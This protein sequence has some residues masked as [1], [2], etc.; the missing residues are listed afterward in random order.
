[1]RILAGYFYLLCYLFVWFWLSFCDC[2]YILTL[3]M[4]TCNYVFYY[5]IF[6]TFLPVNKLSSTSEE[7]RRPKRHIK[8]GAVRSLFHVWHSSDKIAIFSH[9]SSGTKLV[10]NKMASQIICWFDYSFYIH[11][12]VFLLSSTLTTYVQDYCAV[13]IYIYIYIYI[14]VL[15]EIIQAPSVIT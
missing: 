3:G 1:M 2:I 15:H 5:I 13:Y 7:G 11:A 14:Y 4:N 6:L 10:S 12:P 8:A 9:S